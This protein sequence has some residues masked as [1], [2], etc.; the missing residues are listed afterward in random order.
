ML[1][2]VDNWAEAEFLV[3]ELTRRE[4]Q[5]RRPGMG[6]TVVPVGESRRYYGNQLTVHRVSV[7]SP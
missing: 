1:S 2:S 5:F 3:I 4:S 7:L 6:W